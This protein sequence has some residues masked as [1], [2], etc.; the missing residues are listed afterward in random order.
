MTAEKRTYVWR[1]DGIKFSRPRRSLRTRK[2]SR[3]KNNQINYSSLFY[4]PQIYLARSCF[5]IRRLYFKRCNI[6]PHSEYELDFNGK[7]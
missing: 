7:T 3:G 5:C 1:Y 6:Y 2:I 4:L